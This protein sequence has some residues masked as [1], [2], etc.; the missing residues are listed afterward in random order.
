[1]FPEIQA[2][3]MKMLLKLKLEWWKTCWTGNWIDER[4]VT[5]MELGNSTKLIPQFILRRIVRGELSTT[6]CPR[7]FVREELSATNCSATNCPGTTN[8]MH[9]RGD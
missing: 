3:L 5:E 2:G 9:A 7:R 4:N 1:M 6:N 8:C